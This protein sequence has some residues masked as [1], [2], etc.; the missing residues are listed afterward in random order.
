VLPPD[1]CLVGKLK[2]YLL[3]ARGYG[4][5]SLSGGGWLPV[6]SCSCVCFH[7]VVSSLCVLTGEYVASLGA[8]TESWDMCMGKSISSD[9]ANSAAASA[10]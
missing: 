10:G 1:S 6:V 2:C 3:N 5:P 9:S 8:T 4:R 7:L